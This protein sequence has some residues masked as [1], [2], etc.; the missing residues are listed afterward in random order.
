[1][2]R[3]GKTCAAVEE[4]MQL[5]NRAFGKDIK[6]YKSKDVPWRIKVNG[7]WITCMPFSPLE[8][9]PGHGRSRHKKKIKRWETK[10]MTKLVSLK[11]QKE[12][13]WVDYQTRTSIMTRKIWVQMKLPFLNEKIAES[14]W[15]A[16]EWACNEKENAVIFSLKKVHK[17]R[18]TTRWQTLHTRMIKE[19][20][21]NRTRWKQKWE[22]PNRGNV[23]DEMAT[24]WA[25]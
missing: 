21:E 3:Q 8:V 14:T 22:W 5:A 24:C 4:R 11:R 12:E 16:M 25:G 2:N 17:W 6:I 1:M 20:P 13:T 15:R 9:K 18:S 19:D 23:W 10:I 7:W